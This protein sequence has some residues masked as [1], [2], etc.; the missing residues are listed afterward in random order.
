MIGKATRMDGRVSVTLRWDRVQ[1]GAC[2]PR[3]REDAPALVVEQPCRRRGPSATFDVAERCYTAASVSALRKANRRLLVGSLV[4]AG[5]ALAVILLVRFATQEP[6]PWAPGLPEVWSHRGVTGPGAPDNSPAAVDAA[7]RAGFSGVEIDLRWQDGALWVAHDAHSPQRWPLEQV[8]AQRGELS[9]WIDFKALTPEV[10][11]EAGPSLAAILG[12]ARNVW[13]ESTHLEALTVLMQHCPAAQPL[14]RPRWWQ[15][16]P[17]L[18]W[19][20]SMLNTVRARGFARVAW[21]LRDLTPRVVR[22]LSPTQVAAFTAGDA[23]DLEAARAAG[24]HV[25]LT[26]LERP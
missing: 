11:Q 23:E 15:R 19:Y 2:C 20:R 5:L 21:P 8:L 3:W 10:A 17:Y 14:W 24:A 6:R 1:C 18:P 12:S 26:D 13:I 22:D 9:L 4:A 25:I 16:I 7:R